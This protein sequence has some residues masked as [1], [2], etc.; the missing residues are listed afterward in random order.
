[1]AQV[2]TMTRVSG[3]PAIVEDSTH[4][5]I[6][7]HVYDKTTLTPIFG[8]FKGY[9][10]ADATGAVSR[11]ARYC[12]IPDSASADFFNSLDSTLGDPG[13][14]VANH[15]IIEVG[16]DKFYF[17]GMPNSAW[18]SASTTVYTKYDSANIH[19][20]TY[21]QAANLRTV[22]PIAFS[23]T[24]NE[25]F[26]VYADGTCTAT[27]GASSLTYPTT[28]PGAGTLAGINLSY[29]H[30][31]SFLS[32]NAT[33]WFVA[34]NHGTVSAATTLAIAAV[35]KTTRAA[36]T[37]LTATAQSTT[38]PRL[39]TSNVYNQS[40]DSKWTYIVGSNSVDPAFT[41]RYNNYNQ[42]SLTNTG[43]D[44]TI[45]WNGSSSAA[46][47]VALAK[48]SRATQIRT[49]VVTGTADSFVC[50]ASM[51]SGSTTTQTVSTMRMHV[52]KINAGTP[53]SIQFKETVA[54]GT[55]HGRIR[56][57]FPITNNW[58][59]IA[60]MTDSAA[61]LYT[62]DDT[63]GYTVGTT[64][65]YSIKSTSP[66]T[67]GMF[68][69]DM[70]GRIWIHSSGGAGSTISVY[71]PTTATT[72]TLNFASSSYNYTGTTI[73]SSFNLSAY[74]ASGARI[75]TNIQVVLDSAN[76]TFSDDTTTKTITT[77]AGGEVSTNVKITGPGQIRAVAN[78]A[79]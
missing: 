10:N 43:G 4:I 23:A 26:G 51:D 14:L 20:G 5:V 38:Y 35:N 71:S 25:I 47:F 16:S 1:M 67:S 74:N 49:W 39:I 41:I 3:T 69:V 11:L 21:N 68:G 33:Y 7:G 76:I 48:T 24:L 29:V 70:Q 30:S 65:P 59:T 52:F 63:N 44:C 13:G 46:E 42:S 45:D 12:S 9:F 31:T 19:I 50:F 79:V 78:V 15:S 32:E 64:I 72:I 6:N 36:T 66:L 58:R 34:Y 8:Q 53:S 61:T 73:N 37:V 55:T 57:V 60:V 54:I 17:P 22:I 62:W 28:T 56:N 2:A 40:T 27:S 75:A 18:S 77:S